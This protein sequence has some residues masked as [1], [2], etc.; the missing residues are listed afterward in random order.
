MC[1]PD[2]SVAEAALSQIASKGVRAIYL[3]YRGVAL[4]KSALSVLADKIS[5]MGAWGIAVLRG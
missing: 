3:S 1:C 4:I 2:L 5:D